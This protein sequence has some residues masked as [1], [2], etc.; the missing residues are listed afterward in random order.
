MPSAFAGSFFSTANGEKIPPR[1]QKHISF[2]TESGLGL[3]MKIEMCDI[4][5]VLASVDEMVEQGHRAIFEAAHPRIILSNGAVLKMRRERRLFLLRLYI[6][7]GQGGVGLFAVEQS[8]AEQH[9]QR[10]E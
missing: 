1:G 5:K 7:D 2:T 9:F 3:T 8:D 10:Q 6:Q 4:D